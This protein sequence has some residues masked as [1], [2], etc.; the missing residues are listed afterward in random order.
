MEGLAEG[1]GMAGADV[2][3]AGDEL[4]LDM[5]CLGTVGGGFVGGGVEAEE[6]GGGTGGCGGCCGGCAGGRGLESWLGSIV[7]CQAA[8]SG[9]SCL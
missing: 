3:A 2:E 4:E 9:L 6:V 5:I 1:D 7:K 8:S